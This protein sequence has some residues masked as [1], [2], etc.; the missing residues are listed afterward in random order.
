M[1]K[2]RINYGFK[3]TFPNTPF[4][5]KSLLSKGAHPQYI[6][7]YMRVKAALASGVLVVAG[8]KTPDRVRRGR[9]ELVF[10]RADAKTSTLSAASV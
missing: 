5:M 6:T 10:R 4:T 9:K 1:S 8:E 3:L 2:P 7:A